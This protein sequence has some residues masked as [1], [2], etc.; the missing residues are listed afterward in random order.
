MSIPT[1]EQL[2]DY[3]AACAQFT[4]A[5]AALN[6]EQLHYKPNENEWS[7]HDIIIHMGD[8]EIG[9]FWRIRKTVAEE[10]SLLPIYDEAAWQKNLAYE[11]QDRTLALNLFMALRTSTAALLRSLPDDAWQKTSTH[12]ERGEMTLYDIFQLYVEHGQIHLDQINSLKQSLPI[13][14]KQDA[15]R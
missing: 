15:T 10:N 5:I 1:K 12:P 4:V 14:K 2:Q 9:C 8:S 3:E 13:T 11:K 7:V 6:E